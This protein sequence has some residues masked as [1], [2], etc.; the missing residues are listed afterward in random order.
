MA[1]YREAVRRPTRHRAFALVE[2]GVGEA[3]ARVIERA[4][5]HPVMTPPGLGCGRLLPA[6]GMLDHERVSRRVPEALDAELRAG[7][8]VLMLDAACA[9]VF[10]ANLA[11]VMP[12]DSRAAR[13]ARQTLK[14]A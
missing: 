8:P 7:V 10:R 2:P 11:S 6:I 13:L 3:T 4:G 5:A 1:H 14:L 12:D 9:S